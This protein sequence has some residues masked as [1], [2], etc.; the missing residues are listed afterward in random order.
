MINK[1]TLKALGK[2]GAFV[3]LANLPFLTMT[4]LMGME[5]FLDSFQQTEFYQYFKSNYLDIKGIDNSYIILQKSSYPDFS[6][7][8]G[9]DIFYLKDEAGLLCRKVYHVSYAGPLKRYYT[10]QFNGDLCLEPV[11]QYQIIGKVIGIVDNNAWNTL[12][13]KVWDMSINNLNAVALFT[14]N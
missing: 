10:L 3:V 7:V 8:P 2:I 11:Y 4:Q 9:D 6:I 1:K 14:K 5:P 13:L 12:S